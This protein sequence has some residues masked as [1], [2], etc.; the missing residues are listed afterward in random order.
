M[1]RGILPLSTLAFLIVAVGC[2]LLELRPPTPVAADADAR[3]FS[4][5]RAL[6]DVRWI[7]ERPHPIGSPDHAR[8]RGR[9][10]ERFRE[11]SIEAEVQVDTGIYWL[12]ASKVRSA[13]VHN[14][15]ARLPGTRP[16]GKA[17]L[18]CAHYDSV[19]TGPGAADD[20]A[21][22]AVLLETAR[23]LR[24]GPPLE[25]DVL[26]LVTDGEEAGLLGARAFVE[27]HPAAHRVGVVLN[28]EARGHRGPSVMFETSEGN[29]DLVAELNALDRPVSNS[30]AYEIYRRMPNDTDLTIFKRGGV[31][32]LNFAFIGGLSHYHTALDSPGR[33]D[34][35]SLQQHG[36]AALALARRFGAKELGGEAEGD[37]VY[38]SLL[39][40]VLL[41]YPI[42]A[43]WLLCAVTLLLFGAVLRFALRSGRV[44]GDALRRGVRA[45]LTATFLASL[46][47]QLL[48]WLLLRL[49]EG[50][51]VVFAVVNYQSHWIFLGLLALALA[52]FALGLARARP[53]V[54]RDG[55]W[56]AALLLWAVLA[57]LLTIILPGGSFLF[58]WPLLFA[59]GALRF[60]LG[61]AQ[62]R[63]TGVASVAVCSLAVLPGLLLGVPLLFMLFD[64]VTLQG[65]VAVLMLEMALL[66]LITPQLLVLLS[67]GRRLL[68][69]LSALAGVAFVGLAVV[70][71]EPGGE[72]PARSSLFYAVDLDAGEAW[73][74]SFDR[75]LGAWAAAHVGPDAERIPVAT[76]LPGSSREAFLGPAPAVGLPG[77]TLELVGVEQ[78]G[79]VRTFELRLKGAEAARVVAL[80]LDAEVP[81]R[82]LQIGGRQMD[83]L[84]EGEERFVAGNSAMGLDLTH[85]AVPQDGITITLAIQ[86]EQPLRLTTI[87]MLDGFA[88]A[89]AAGLAIDERPEHAIVERGLGD[90][91]FVKRTFTF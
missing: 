6:E 50:Q 67:A 27:G 12:S 87:S 78:T 44:S 79:E 19:P 56:C 23:A 28:F 30:M 4:A 21:G 85:L 15:L 73:F 16:G 43:G 17:V 39:G 52:V 81:V 26:L 2:A 89:I 35:G 75:V 48:V 37:R 38:F 58:C 54:G 80:H 68:P 70:R 49:A 1:T 24:A 25:N 40:R 14:I 66:A 91:C 74:G 63:R 22:V 46:V 9:L 41:H 71:A 62:P 86:G 64:A 36:D 65:V 47:T 8:I 51:P 59:C 7:A 29:G 3:R 69:A 32:G 83:P 42:W 18:L 76:V 55:L 53:R 88:A 57:L 84:E 5:E 34:L 72:Q 20:A 61:G 77:P 10:L 82:V 11:L 33:L 45:L 13:T 90:V 31:R 60:C